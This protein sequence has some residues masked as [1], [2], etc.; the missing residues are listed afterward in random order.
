MKFT[1]DSTKL[2]IEEF[3]VEKFKAIGFSVIQETEE[4]SWKPFRVEPFEK[5]INS[6]EEL[7]DFQKSVGQEIIISEN[8]IEIYNDYRE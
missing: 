5:E 8:N 4:D 2:Y 7:I 6:L 1:I 3:E